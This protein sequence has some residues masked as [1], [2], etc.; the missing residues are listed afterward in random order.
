MYV[1]LPEKLR[2]QSLEEILGQEHLT[3]EK[4]LITHA[5]KKTKAALNLTVG[6]RQGVGRRR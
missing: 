4:G 6:G 2:P 3:G 1:P 5:V